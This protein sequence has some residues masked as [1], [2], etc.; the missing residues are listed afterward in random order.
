MSM[1]RL[2]ALQHL[3]HRLGAQFIPRTPEDFIGPARRFARDIQQKIAD[4]NT[5][6]RTPLAFLINGEPGIGKSMLAAFALHQLGCHPQWS[7]TRLSGTQVKIET[8]E[9]LARTLR[10]RDMFGDWRAIWIEE[11]DKIPTVAQ[12]RFLLLMDELPAGTAVLCTSNCKLDQFEKRF[13]TR[14]EP[15]EVGPAPQAEIEALLRPYPLPA[16]D[17][18]SI[19]T[20]ACGSVR[21]A[22]IDARNALS[23]TATAQ[24]A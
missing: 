13:Q 16:R 10:L 6:G 18:K 14:F 20:F 19:A 15:M 7:V 2:Q 5:L 17:I 24:A 8:V 3:T 4:A 9:D 21:T 11:A 22:L 23:S 1:T 12:V